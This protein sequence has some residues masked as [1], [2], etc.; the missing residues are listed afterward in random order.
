MLSQ[1]QFWKHNEKKYNFERNAS[2]GYNGSR[3]EWK[4][5]AFNIESNTVLSVMKVTQY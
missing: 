5:C 2:F 4:Q 3:T 1:T